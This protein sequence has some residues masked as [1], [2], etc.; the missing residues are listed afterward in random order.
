[1]RF[2]GVK[3]I[4]SGIMFAFF[5]YFFVFLSCILL[6]FISPR[7][8]E[9]I[10]KSPGENGFLFSAC[11]FRLQIQA[12]RTRTCIYRAK[13]VSKTSARTYTISYWGCVAVSAACHVLLMF[14]FCF[15]LHLHFKSWVFC[16]DSSGT[17]FSVLCHL[18][19]SAWTAGCLRVGP[20]RIPTNVGICDCLGAQPRSPLGF[21]TVHFSVLFSMYDGHW[22]REVCTGWEKA[23][24]C[25][26]GKTKMC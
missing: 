14:S 25:S 18:V 5:L 10:A 21:M 8:S 4:D 7:V 11:L 16:F 26:K 12:A 6:I 20:G 22:T 13:I 24:D 23:G 3:K 17:S 2:T 9:T 15:F 19:I 1:M